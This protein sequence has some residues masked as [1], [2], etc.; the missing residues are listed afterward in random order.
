M[1]TNIWPLGAVNMR[2]AIYTRVSTDHQAED[3]FS[4]EAQLSR[5]RSYCHSQGWS[6]AGV[7][8]DEGIS[9]KDIQR[10]ALTR[11]LH[12]VKE[13]KLDVVL[14]YKLDRLTRSVRDLDELLSVFHAY[15]V[16]FKSATELY[17]T[18]TATGRLFLHLVAS[19]AQWERETIA[20]RTRVGQEQMTYEGKWSGGRAPFGYDYVDGQLYVNPAQAEV[21]RDLFQRYADGQGTAS[22]LAWLNHPLHP[23]LAPNRRWTQWGLKYVLRNPLY[24]GY[25]RYGYRTGDGRKQPNPI[26]AKGTHE[27]II[28]EDLWQRSDD[29]RRRRFR[30]PAA[31]HTGIY[32]LTGV[33]RCGRCGAAMS[34]RTKHSSSHGKSVVK[35]Y[36]ACNERQQSRL[37]DM[38]MIQQEVIEEAILEQIES[39]YHARRGIPTEPDADALKAMERLSSDIALVQRRRQRWMNA[40]EEGAITSFELRGRLDELNDEEHLLQRRLVEL[41]T[42]TPIDVG[43]MQKLTESFRSTWDSCEPFERK[44]IIHLLVK[45]LDVH[46]NGEVVR[47]RPAP[48]KVHIEFHN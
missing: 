22:L 41:Q 10:P 37:C 31:F 20:E 1:Q 33:L 19:L 40:F 7:Y 15:G 44:E 36:Y 45:R 46:V 34:G 17:D 28:S 24:A 35:R 11:L 9:G 12:D 30:R 27:A 42:Q 5:L 39:L 32:P 13:G 29:V 48:F 14:V 3:G 4:L 6:E 8:T 23:Q 38:P 26:I 43:F 16:G 25:V 21:V 2:T 47:N 18:T